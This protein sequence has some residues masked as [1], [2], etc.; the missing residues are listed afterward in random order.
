[1]KKT[2]LSLTAQRIFPVFADHRAAESSH[3]A[4][5]IE[6]IRAAC[7]E[8]GA[9]EDSRPYDC[10]TPEWSLRC[11]HCGSVYLI[12]LSGDVGGAR[13]Q[14]SHACKALEKIQAFIQ[15]RTREGRS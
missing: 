1:M 5:R 14:S 2:T 7:A 10:T 8:L 13:G 12:H 15:D 11:P 9:V 4:R 6:K 3:R